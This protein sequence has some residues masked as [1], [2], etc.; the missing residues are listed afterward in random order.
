LKRIIP[1]L[2]VATTLLNGCIASRSFV[3]FE[4][5]QPAIITYPESVQNIGYLNRAPL[6][7]NSF[8]KKNRSNM[9]QV[10]LIMIDTMIC[11][12]LS[13][14][15]MEARDD[16]KLP[17]LEDIIFLESRRRDTL[18]R[19]EPLSELYKKTLFMQHQLDALIVLEYYNFI[20]LS[21]SNSFYDYSSHDYAIEYNLAAEVLWKVYVQG[22]DNTLNEYSNTDT[23]FFLNTAS[24][25]DS[26]HWNTVRVIQSGFYEIGHRYGERHIPVW[27][28]VSRIIF[29]GGNSKMVKAAELTDKGDWESAMQLWIP[30]SENEDTQTSAK[31]LNNIAVYYELEDNIE[32]S[33]GFAQS[34]VEK[35]D[36]ENIKSYVQELEIRLL[37]Q[38]DIYKQFRQ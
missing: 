31:A 1:I 7:I 8:S 13:K 25:P 23:L 26:V 22:K 36:C 29:R 27:S 10:S 38:K 37:N 2:F 11:N 24:A 16:T 12:N 34:A 14:G 4:V 35:W 3:T 9:D 18:A 6:S 33:L 20:G 32:T 15:F 21:R 17:Y 30:L 5:L 19:S 28:N